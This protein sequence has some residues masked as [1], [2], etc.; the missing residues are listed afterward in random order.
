METLLPALVPA[1]Q[2]SVRRYTHLWKRCTSWALPS[3]W[4][5]S[6]AS[7]CRERQRLFSS[8]RNQPL[9]HEG[10]RMTLQRAKIKARKHPTCVT[11]KELK[12]WKE[13]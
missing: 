10:S 13:V 11:E 4:L 2:R 9:R 3:M 8:C 7:C 12:D 5:R 1:R 6:S